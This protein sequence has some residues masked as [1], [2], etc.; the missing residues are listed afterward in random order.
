MTDQLTPNMIS[1][2]EFKIIWSKTYNEIGKPDWSHIF[3]YYDDS[4]IFPFNGLKALFSL[5]QCVIA[6]LNVVEV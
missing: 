4:I 6:S 2:E 1:V 5:K 3:P